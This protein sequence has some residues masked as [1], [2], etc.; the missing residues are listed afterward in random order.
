[1]KPSAGSNGA[2]KADG[3]AIAIGEGAGIGLR[4]G[5][6]ELKTK[7]ETALAAVKADGWLDALIARYFPELKG[8]PFFK[9]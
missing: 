7:F 1:M 6:T 3:P 4:Q 2:L 9:N 5:D 8:G